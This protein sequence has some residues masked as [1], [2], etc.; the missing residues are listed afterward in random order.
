MLWEK[1]SKNLQK[2][3]GVLELCCFEWFPNRSKEPYI[4]Q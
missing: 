1:I 3:I 2:E 4:V